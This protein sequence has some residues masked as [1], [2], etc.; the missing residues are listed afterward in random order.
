MV[1]QLY[2]KM[3]AAVG[4]DGLERVRGLLE[5]VANGVVF[6]NPDPLYAALP[7]NL[8]FPG[9][10]APQPWWDPS[11][12][13]W[14]AELEASK[15]RIVT[16]VRERLADPEVASKL[17]QY[18]M[19]ETGVDA[20]WR[21][22]AFY[23][24]FQ[25]NTALTSQ[26]PY[27]KSLLDRLPVGSDASIS[28]LQPGG[29]VKPHSDNYNFTLTCHLALDI[30]E[31]TQLTVGGEPRSWEEGK[32]WIFDHSYTH[33]G[34]NHGGRSRVVL[35]LNVFHFDLTAK[36]IAVLKMFGQ[37]LMAFWMA[38]SGITA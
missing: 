15:D 21:A 18:G 8:V 30:P 20:G 24:Y 27:L 10:P 34:Y 22:M 37:E 26:F 14:V 28:I 19:D 4:A 32:C 11:V 29:W 9:L 3:V 38:A 31:G 33:H 16:E 36:E 23:K 6:S 2:E 1:E 17:E 12:Y 13:P 7:P 35:I 25:E 5:N